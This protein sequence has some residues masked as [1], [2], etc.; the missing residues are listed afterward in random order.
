MYN[1][2]SDTL[3]HYTKRYDTL[4]SILEEG[5]RVS[6]S[7]EQIT[8]DHFIGIPM[9]SFCDI[10]LELSREHREKYGRYAIGVSKTRLIKSMRRN[11]SPVHYV[12][13]EGPILGAFRHHNDAITAENCRQKFLERKKVSGAEKITFSIFKTGDYEG[14]G[15]E[16]NDSL[17]KHFDALLN[18]KTLANNV[19][20]ITKNYICSH[21]GEE[22]CAYDEC[23]WRIVIPED[24]KL[25]GVNVPWFWSKEKYDSW[26]S[27]RE[28]TFLCTIELEPEDINAIVVDTE[29]EKNQL[30]KYLENGKY[31]SV[32]ILV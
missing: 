24:F 26:K 25:D 3:F 20:G 6:Y 4:I 28:N 9:I 5:L 18:A 31:G 1:S 10:P 29:T 2:H 21:D 16:L 15:T 13:E 12:L 7:G 23:E 8:K 30:A 17:T 27:S 32:Q 11:L 14:Y 19:L 22:F